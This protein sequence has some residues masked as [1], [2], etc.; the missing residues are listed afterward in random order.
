MPLSKS[1]KIG[2][3]IGS[4]LA[5]LICVGIVVFAIVR[6]R[7]S[8]NSVKPPSESVKQPLDCNAIT[9]E[10]ELQKMGIKLN[11]NHPRV[12]QTLDCNRIRSELETK[13][14]Q[15]KLCKDKK[16][17]SNAD[18]P[19]RYFC[20]HVDGYEKEMPSGQ[21]IC[22]ILPTALRKKNPESMCINS[23]DCLNACS[24]GTFADYDGYC[25]KCPPGT[26]SRNDE[27]VYCEFV[28][29]PEILDL[30]IPE[31]RT[32]WE[33]NW[34]THGGVFIPNR[35]RTDIE[36]TKFRQVYVLRGFTEREEKAI[37]EFLRTNS[38]GIVKKEINKCTQF[39]IV[40]DVSNM[41]PKDK[42]LANKYN[43]EI[44]SGDFYLQR[45][46]GIRQ[47]NVNIACPAGK[48]N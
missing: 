15:D 31:N 16:C 40:K 28:P 12:K 43:V 19:G 37:K 2:I 9:S 44:T 11:T 25:K 21:G 10:V 7:S 32:Y 3:A 36:K 42:E 1:K 18:C 20:I 45:H 24:P 29:T 30:S 23:M 5:G 34:E 22:A 4:I 17:T 6:T 35:E 41:D 8:R 33:S 39:L 38:F 26:Y 47:D 48:S 13:I 14:K 46:C 27:N